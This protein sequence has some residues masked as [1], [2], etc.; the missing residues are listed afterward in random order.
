LF[1]FSRLGA[2]AGKT[3]GPAGARHAMEQ[4]LCVLRW[5]AVSARVIGRPREPVAGISEGGRE[6]LPGFAEQPVEIVG[7]GIRP[8]FV[9]VSKCGICHERISFYEMNAPAVIGSA[10]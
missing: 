9:L 2:D 1:E 10:G 7:G 5:R 4:A 8:P 3:E 6:A